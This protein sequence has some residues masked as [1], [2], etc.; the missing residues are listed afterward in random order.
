MDT[1]SPQPHDHVAVTD[2]DW[3]EAII[4]HENAR[5]ARLNDGTR[6]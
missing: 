1:V 2:Q 5:A 4:A 3:P 6:T